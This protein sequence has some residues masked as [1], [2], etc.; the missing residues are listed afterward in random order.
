MEVAKGGAA[1][2]P[3]VLREQRIKRSPIPGAVLGAVGGVAAIVGAGLLGGAAS[4]G[5]SAS[6]QHDAIAA[7]GHNC[8]TVGGPGY[9]A[10]CADLLA[11]RPSTADALHGAGVGLLIGAGAAAVGALTYFLWPKQGAADTPAPPLRVAPAA[12]ANGGGL[13]FL[14]TF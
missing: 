3:L 14:G 4:K 6:S 2:V 11:S 13:L 5:S 1:E 10:R 8:T 7:A 12:S 9:D